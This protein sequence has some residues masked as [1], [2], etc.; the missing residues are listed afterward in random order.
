MYFLTLDI[1][2]DAQRWHGAVRRAIWHGRREHEGSAHAG[3]ED[4]ML[5]LSKVHGGGETTTCL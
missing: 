3:V 4:A 1:V 5:L 2:F